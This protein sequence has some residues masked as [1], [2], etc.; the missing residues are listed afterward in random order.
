MASASCIVYQTQYYQYLSSVEKEMGF[1]SVADL[2]NC[3][4]V[5]LTEVFSYETSD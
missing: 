3:V 5:S 1:H 2:M 4:L